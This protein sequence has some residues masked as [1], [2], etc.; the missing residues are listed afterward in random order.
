MTQVLVTG[1]GG[2]V[3]QSI[4]K[5][6]QATPYSVVAVDSD[7]WPRASMARTAATRCRWPPVGAVRH[8]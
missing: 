6:L 5:S 7:R 4:V 3:G 1:V 2:G 8:A